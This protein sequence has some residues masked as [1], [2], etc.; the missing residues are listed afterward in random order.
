MNRYLVLGG[1]QK[2]TTDAYKTPEYKGYER[3]IG[4]VVD[5]DTGEAEKVLDYVSPESNRNETE[6]ASVLFKAGYMDEHY[7][8]ACTQTEVLLYSAV[9]FHLKKVISLPCFN[10][11]HHVT[12]S[13]KGTLLVVS[14][15]LDTLFELSM[16]GEL[17]N[18]WP[19]SDFKTWEV[20]DRSIDYRKVL[21]TKPHINHANFCFETDQG[22]WMTRHISKDAICLQTGDVMHVGDR[23]P[24]DGEVEG[25]HVYFTTVDGKV[26]RVSLQDY[27]DKTEFD[28]GPFNNSDINLGWCRGLFVKNESEFIVGFSRLRP[29]KYDDYTRWLKRAVKKD[30]Y[31][32]SLPTRIAHYDFGRQAL[33]NEINLERYDLNC[34]FSILK[35]G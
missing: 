30:A 2:K 24:H 34:V 13:R 12:R 23:G 4:L 32:G 15:G 17:L 3:G 31:A 35:L 27:N 22:Y 18:E 5:L 1:K 7:L 11:I 19:S 14:T 10:D 9:D 20:Y 21:T 29:S 25:D 16:E 28:L 6:D 26:I 33:V 8:V